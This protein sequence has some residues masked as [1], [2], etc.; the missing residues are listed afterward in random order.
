LRSA[1]SGGSGRGAVMETARLDGG[2]KSI[3]KADPAWVNPDRSK[4]V[5][6]R[7]GRIIYVEMEAGNE[8]QGNLWQL[9][10]DSE[11]G[12]PSGNPTKITNWYGIIPTS[13]SVS[14][15]GARLVATKSH[16]R[17]EIY[18]GELK[19]SG[20]KLDPA[21]L[22]APSDSFDSPSGWTL[23]SSAIL[24]SSD[25]TRTYQAYRQSLTR[26]SIEAL[27]PGPEAQRGAQM[28][29]DGGWI[30]YWA[31]SDA[32]SQ[33]G[34]IWNLMR[35]SSSGGEPEPV[36]DAPPDANDTFECA[37]DSG[38][39][40]YLGRWKE[41]TLAFYR[42]SAV[43]RLGPEVARVKVERPDNLLWT[44]SSDG[45]RIAVTGEDQTPD[46]IRII[47]IRHANR[48]SSLS[49]PKG[50]VIWSLRWMP[51]GDAL[52]AT[53][54]QPPDFTINRM[55]LNGK[56]ITIYADHTYMSS[57]CPSPD[58]RHLAFSKRTIEGNAWLIENF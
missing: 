39:S 26:H 45:G 58:G 28:S 41:G 44:V 31:K 29:P 27:A 47:D 13:I 7:D 36:F 35:I 2:G 43:T 16:L 42:L 52:I 24:F 4:I 37:H 53:V 8:F 40:C 49:I 9:R 14:S 20:T 50:W 48:E 6:L 51:A 33:S 46:Q 55:G 38:T 3:V 1:R 22:I 5:W 54:L 17:D 34:S 25:R 18:L 21:T 10:V 30:L 56:N 32:N 11:S 15:D 57:A 12:T 23:D 19:D